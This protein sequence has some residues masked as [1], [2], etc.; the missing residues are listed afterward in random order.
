[1]NT[2]KYFLYNPAA[3]EPD[4]GMSLAQRLIISKQNYQNPGKLAPSYQE[5]QPY[6]EE[7][8]FLLSLLNCTFFQEDFPLSFFDSFPLLQSLETCNNY[9]EGNW[10]RGEAI[11][12]P[13]W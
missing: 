1:M 8:L 10:R 2:I 3:L 11:A 12:L 7:S 5:R 13:G 4:K 9:T 6:Q